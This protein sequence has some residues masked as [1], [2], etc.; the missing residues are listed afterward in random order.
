MQQ[1]QRS[2]KRM[3]LKSQSSRILCTCGYADII[4]NVTEEPP[5]TEEKG[6]GEPV[7]AEAG[8]N[9]VVEIPTTSDPVKDSEIQELQSQL[10]QK[11]TQISSLQ[12]KL[13]ALKSQEALHIL[14]RLV[15]VGKIQTRHLSKFYHSLLERQRNRLLQIL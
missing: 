2:R 10:L 3:N 4:R 5:V 13:T 15:I 14:E 9:K 12:E 11:D 8:V 1:K 6:S 7:P